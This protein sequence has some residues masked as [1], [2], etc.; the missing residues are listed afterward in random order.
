MI[1]SSKDRWKLIN[2][3][4]EPKAEEIAF[5]LSQCY[6]ARTRPEY[7]V[8][9]CNGALGWLSTIKACI[10]RIEGD[11]ARADFWQRFL[12]VHGFIYQL[13]LSKFSEQSAASLSVL[14]KHLSATLDQQKKSLEL[15]LEER[16]EAER[17]AKTTNRLDSSWKRLLVS[18]E[19]LRRLG[20]HVSHLAT[21][22]YNILETSLAEDARESR[23]S[24]GMDSWSDGWNKMW[25]SEVKAKRTFWQVLSTDLL[26]K[27]VSW[28]TAIWHMTL[29]V[30]IA[31]AVLPRLICLFLCT[32][33]RHHVSKW[34]KNFMILIAAAFL[35]VG[36]GSITQCVASG[37]IAAPLA[38]I[39]SIIL[40]CLPRQVMGSRSSRDPN[41]K[42]R[43]D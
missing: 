17:L 14:S 38:T 28:P 29:I 20:E 7:L 5:R 23:N 10:G 39:A 2:G 27:N 1:L 15:A 26:A 36:A 6:W 4:L 34:M 32:L 33:N 24:N 16:R 41:R 9:S 19:P 22:V 3:N 18:T 37:F 31:L 21:S 25:N 35:Y 12:A 11:S 8:T 30:P 42:W 13:N 40:E 43:E